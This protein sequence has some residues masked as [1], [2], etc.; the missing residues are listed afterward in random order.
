MEKAKEQDFCLLQGTDKLWQSNDWCLLCPRKHSY[1][2]RIIW[3][4]TFIVLHVIMFLKSNRVMCSFS[5]NLVTSEISQGLRSRVLC[6]GKAQYPIRCEIIGISDISQGL[7][8]SRVWC[9]GNILHPVRCESLDISQGRGSYN[10]WCW[11]KASHPR[12]SD[13]QKSPNDISS[14][15]TQFISC[16]LDKHFSVFEPSFQINISSL[17]ASSFVV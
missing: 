1:S 14:L 13:N 16:L 8:W 10:R 17:L 15:Q 12:W 9:I 3:C 6:C 7:W 11:G 2:L 5:E 4:I